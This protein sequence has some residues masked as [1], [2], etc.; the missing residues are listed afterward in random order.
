MKNLSENNLIR[1]KNISKKKTGLFAN[2]LMTVV[3]GGTNIRAVINVD[4]AAAEVDL[5]APMEE[6]I[7][8]CALIAVK[9]VKSAECQFEGLQS[10]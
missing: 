5:S 10:I 8:K 9:D 6:I 4:V 1:F 3:R 7:Q 2:F